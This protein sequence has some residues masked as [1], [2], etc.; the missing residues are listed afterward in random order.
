MY[1]AQFEVSVGHAPQTPVSNGAQGAP[2]LILVLTEQ[3]LAIAV[4]SFD[5]ECVKYCETTVNRI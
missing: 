5:A 4:A 3:L 2:T 1:P